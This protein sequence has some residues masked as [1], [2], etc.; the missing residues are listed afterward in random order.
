MDHLLPIAYF[1]MSARNSG[2]AD[3]VVKETNVN[4]R[5]NYDDMKVDFVKI[6]IKYMSRV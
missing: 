6:I 3:T 1:E 2:F 5:N 4:K